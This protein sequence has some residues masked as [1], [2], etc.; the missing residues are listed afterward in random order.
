M[1][2][3]DGSQPKAEDVN[4][5]RGETTGA[6]S[7][8]IRC[9]LALTR[10]RASVLELVLERSAESAAG[11][12]IFCRLWINQHVSKRRFVCGAQ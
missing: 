7:V 6:A 8:R 2:S 5:A 3:E 1:E 11:G 10:R 12:F 9:I 4:D